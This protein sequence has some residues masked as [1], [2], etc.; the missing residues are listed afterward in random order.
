MKHLLWHLRQSKIVKKIIKQ[1]PQ[2]FPS[3]VAQRTEKPAF[4][5]SFL[6]G[7]PAVWVRPG[8]EPTTFPSQGHGRLTYFLRYGLFRADVVPLGRTESGT[9][10]LSVE[11]WRGRQNLQLRT[12]LDPIDPVYPS[13]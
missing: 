12:H 2:S 4:V 7:L 8:I 1:T 5:S 10:V 6:L 11:F 13:K 3:L 9:S